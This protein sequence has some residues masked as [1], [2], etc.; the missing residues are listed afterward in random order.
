M[1]RCAGAIKSRCFLPLGKYVV[2]LEDLFL[3]IKKVS[4]PLY[5]VTLSEKKKESTFEV[6][7]GVITGSL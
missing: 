6:V 1:T 4:K 7:P 3:I 2:P 5:D